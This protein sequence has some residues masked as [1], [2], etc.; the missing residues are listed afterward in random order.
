[1]RQLD[2]PRLAIGIHQI[3]DQLDVVLDELGLVGMS[4][5]RVLTR[6]LFDGRGRRPA[7]AAWSTLGGHGEHYT[8]A[9]WR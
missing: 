3:R 8:P 6:L 7:V 5:G 4:H 2:R 9:P 1:M